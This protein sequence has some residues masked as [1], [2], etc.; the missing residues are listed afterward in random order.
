[1]L[2][3]VRL[4]LAGVIALQGA[5]A[6]A[7][8]VSYENLVEPVLSGGETVVGEAVV[9]PTSAPARVTAVIVTVPPGGE[10]GWHTHPVPLFGYMLQGALTVTYDGHGERTY[11]TGEAL[12]EAMKTRHNGRNAG[13]E[14]V[15]ILTVYIGADGIPGA[16]AAEA[17][18]PEAEQTASP[19]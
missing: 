19:D 11:R 1:M 4:P 8:Q 5:A 14:P 16:A 13:P 18:A 3:I 17:P 6:S 2:P 15:R 12:L 9:Y 10:T 7:Q